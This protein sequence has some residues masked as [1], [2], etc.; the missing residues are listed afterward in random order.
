MN[1]GGELTRPRPVTRMSGPPL[2]GAKSRD[3]ARAH[4]QR[5][6][7]Q[8][9]AAPP[10]EK[11]ARKQG[12]KTSDDGVAVAWLM[13]EGA[14]VPRRAGTL[15][16]AAVTVTCPGTSRSTARNVA[17]RS[18]RNRHRE[19]AVE[20][21]PLQAPPRRRNVAPDP[22]SPPGH[23]RVHEAFARQRCTVRSGARA[24]HGG[25]A[26]HGC[27]REAVRRREK[28]AVTLLDAS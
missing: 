17:G 25:R 28:V 18:S 13:R 14:A 22:Q 6:W 10:A 9:P 4:R 23:G 2:G 8:F 5:Q 7:S 24:R 27:E 15:T 20:E 16:C 19:R 3:V 21:A 11:L 26:A 1:S 12:S